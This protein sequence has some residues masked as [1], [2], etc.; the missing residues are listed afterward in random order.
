MQE[1]PNPFRERL[2]LLVP[3]NKLT[4]RQQDQLLAAAEVLSYRKHESLV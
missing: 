1:Q 2:S 4:P 3:L